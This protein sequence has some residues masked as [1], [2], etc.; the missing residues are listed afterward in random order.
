MKKILTLLL[1]TPAITYA[2]QIVN[3]TP[4]ATVTTSLAQNVSF[5]STSLYGIVGSTVADSA[6]A[7]NVGE[8]VDGSKT[9]STSGSS[10]LGT[11][12]DSGAS[13]ALTAGDWDI[14]F[15]AQVEVDG[16]TA[17][18]AHGG[19]SHLTLT[20]NSNTVIT[21]AQ[22]GFANTTEP[23]TLTWVSSK[24]RVSISGSTTYKTR[25]TV[26]DNGGA[27]LT[28]SGCV[29]NGSA[30]TPITLNARRVR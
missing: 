26:T 30:N 11:Y 29:L 25:F 15:S 22:G 24:K 6:A 16:A 19:V 14:Y 28:I 10:T 3:P 21:D 8:F 12:T 1:L 4:T 5:S 18:G 2:S 27:A 9:S 23:L 13:I 17:V 20:D 7:G